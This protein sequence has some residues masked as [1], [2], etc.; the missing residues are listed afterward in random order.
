MRSRIRTYMVLFGSSI[1]LPW[2]AP[3]AGPGMLHGSVGNGGSHVDL[4][5]RKVTVTPVRA[6]VGDV[7]RI[8]MEWEYWGDISN[9]YYDTTVAE[10]SANGKVVASR[11]FT[12]DFG[13]R[14]GEVYRETFLWDT[15][16][17]APGRYLIRGE[18]PLRLDATPFDNFLAVKEPLLLVPAGESFPDGKERGGEAVAENLFW[19]ER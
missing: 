18:V 1:L 19:V 13:A 12:Y 11:P 6:N 16:G 5:V 9:N 8:E 4:V 2:F 3:L 7:V 17:M 14:L 15:K 10:V